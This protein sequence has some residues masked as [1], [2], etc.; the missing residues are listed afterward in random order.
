MFALPTLLEF[1]ALFA[2]ER[3]TIR[4]PGG[5]DVNPDRP[6]TGLAFSGG[7]IR[8]ATFNLG[9]VQALSELKLLREFD[10][11]SCVSGGGYIGGWLSAFINRECDGKVELAEAKLVTGGDEHSAIRFLRSYSNYLTPQTGLFSSDTLTAVSTF[12]RNLYLNLTLVILALA[13]VLL[14]PRLLVGGVL[15]L[16][17][18]NGIVLPIGYVPVVSLIGI[19]CAII[20]MLFA[21][22]NLGCRCATPAPW[23]TQQ[24]WVLLLI[25]IPGLLSAW[26]I[27]YGFYANEQQPVTLGLQYWALWVGMVYV[28]PWMLGWSLG[29]LSGSSLKALTQSFSK[30]GPWLCTLLF[31]SLAGAFGVALLVAFTH[32]VAAI[33]RDYCG[34]WIV[35]ALA[36]LLLIKFY[37]LTVIGHIGLMGRYFSHESRE[38]WSRLGGW[39]LLF[40]LGW[41]FLFLVVFLAPAFFRWAPQWFLNSGAITWVTATVAGVLLG[42]H[43]A[44]SGGQLRKKWLDIVAQA[45]PFIFIVGLLGLLSFGLHQLLLLMSW[46][47]AGLRLFGGQWPGVGESHGTAF[48]TVLAH[49]AWHFDTVPLLLVVLLCAG[50]FIA[51]A[52]LAWRFNVNLFSIYHFYRQRLTRCYLGASRCKA[53]TP[54]PFTGFDQQDDLKLA[55]LCHEEN[56]QLVCQRPY[57]IFNTA[58]NLVSGK[59]LAWQERLATAFSFTPLACGYCFTLPDEK[60]QRMSF[61]RPASEY[62]EGVWLGSAMSISGA[63]A[64]PNMGY[65]S[66]PAVTFLMTVFNVRLGHWSPNPA[67]AKTW[68]QHDPVFGGT[69]LLKELFG[70]TDYTSSFVYLSD[71]G[72]FENLGV[73]EL[74]RRRVTTI[75]VIDAGQDEHSNY[76]DLGNAIR[77]CYADFGVVID[78]HADALKTGYHAVGSIR[79]PRRDGESAPPPEGTLIYLKPAL[80]GSVPV[81]LQNYGLTHKGFPHQSTVDQCFDE[82]Q[83]ESYR[84][85][86][87]WIGRHVFQQPSTHAPANA[88]VLAHISAQM[89]KTA[90]ATALDTAASR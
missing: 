10:Y 71:G 35:S 85:L 21:G 20:A 47:E 61:Y 42:R 73:Y 2:R 44:S 9:I 15:Y 50:C 32:I 79:Y 56:H 49:E 17:D 26:L 75:V 65:H 5:G 24:K 57:P 52:L 25:V 69:Y 19:V 82:S 64:S 37:S 7:G 63:A 27:S 46:S 86:G 66:S 83:F 29:Y 72:H 12:V 8:S 70:L 23:Y 11:L 14:L 78:I 55:A 38:W 89:R 81:D 58:M 45:M 13:S 16:S 74:V 88:S 77:K 28:L 62:M 4:M 51:A 31:A 43:P 67:N 41:S 76:D 59:Q 40:A 48:M 84:K 60:G 34:V 1:D 39:V 54:H 87:H 18:L 53:R 90:L 22:M 80:T 36:T 68:K 3:K 6:L 30:P 33:P